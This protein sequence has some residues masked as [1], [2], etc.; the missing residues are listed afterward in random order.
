MQLQSRWGQH[1]R[2]TICLFLLV[3]G[4]VEHIKERMLCW[5][6]KNS[7]NFITWLYQWLTF[8]PKSWAF[9]ATRPA[10]SITLGFDVFVQLVIA[11]I[12]TLPCFSSAGCPWKSNFATLP[13]ASFG[14]ANPC[15]QS[16]HYGLHWCMFCAFKWVM[17]PQVG[18]E[19]RE[20]I[21]SASIRKRICLL[22]SNYYNAFLNPGTVIIGS[23]KDT[24]D[25]IIFWKLDWLPSVTL[26]PIW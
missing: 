12:T 3:A 26:Y 16:K 10:P 23:E 4:K 9:F 8:N 20:T 7:S 24:R 22:H 15:I 13:C 21:R 17:C 2:N 6:L 11:A 18:G 19:Y 5:N 25:R 14:I 1:K